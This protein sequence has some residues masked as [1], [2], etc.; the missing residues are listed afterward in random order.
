MH[1]KTFCSLRWIQSIQVCN[2]EEGESQLHLEI[3]KYYENHNVVPDV[4]ESYKN[5]CSCVNVPQYVQNM[6]KMVH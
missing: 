5:V 3:T 1:D 6:E 4:L 2:E